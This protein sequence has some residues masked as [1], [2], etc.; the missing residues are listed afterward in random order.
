MNLKAAYAGGALKPTDVDTLWVHVTCAWFRPEI[1]FLNGVIMEPAV[2]LLKIPSHTFVKVLVL[3]P[4]SLQNGI[5]YCC[6]DVYLLAVL[7]KTGM[8]KVLNYIPADWVNVVNVSILIVNHLLELQTCVIC[9]QSHGSCTECYK[10]ATSFHT[11]CA[12]RAGYQMELHCSEKNGTQI[13][14]WISY[15]AVHRAPNPD[16]VLVIQT[17]SGIFSTRSLLQSQKQEHFFRG[18]RLV[19]CKTAEI[20]DVSKAET[21]DVEPFSAARCRIFRRSNKKTERYRVCFGRSG[22]HGWGLFA[23]RSMQEGDMV[24]HTLGSCVCVLEYRGEQVRRSIADLREARYWSEGKDCYLFKISDEV[25]IDA[26]NKGNIARLINHSCMPNCYARIISM[27]DE[28]SRIVLIAKSDVAAGDELTYEDDLWTEIAKY[29]D[30]KSLVKL[31]STCRWFNQVMMEECIWKFACLRDLQVPYPQV[32]AS[33]WIHLYAS[34]FNGSHSYMF[35][36]PEKHIDWMRIGAFFFDSPVAFLMEK[37]ILPV[38]KSQEETTQKMLQS[39]GSCKLNNI[40]TGIWIADLQLVRCPVCDLNTCDGTMQT[41]DAR[42]I[43]LFLSKG[44]QD[45]SWEYEV[46]GSYDIKKHADGASGGIFDVKHIRDPSTSEV[47][48]LKPWVGKADDWQPKAIVT[49]HGVA[50][51]TNLQENEGLQ[52]KYHAMRAGTDGE[53]VAI[54]ISQQ[55]L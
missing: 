54:R 38:R 8:K 34:A 37:L 45:G 53:V 47:F 28:V 22:I 11:M 26:T 52:I 51:N 35:R 13:T 4:K 21:N 40:K 23:R 12:S 39:S 48:D 25:V 20:H 49:L 3:F 44:Y 2:G 18:S 19:P 30:G 31:A 15:C 7:G 9:K 42:H 24:L 50:V 14:K 33:K 27:D 5:S 46:L 17:P 43:E 41:L 55:L 10:C 36:Q 6:N 32:V 1:A 16:N 29:L